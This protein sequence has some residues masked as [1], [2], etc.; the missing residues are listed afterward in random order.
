[1]ILNTLDHLG[2]FDAKGDKGFF[3]RYSLSSKAFRVY[4]K[5][6]RHIEENLHIDF[7]ESKAIDKG[8]GLDWLFN[9]E[10]LTKSMNY[11]PVV[12]AGSSSTNNSG[13]QE[14]VKETVKE[15]ESPLRFIALT[16]WFHEAQEATSNVAAKKCDVALEINS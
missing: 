15:K 1:M 8:A 16:N 14:D 11:V 6:T 2:K 13:T 12:V 7:L 3:V 10:S 4:N 5:R 9:I